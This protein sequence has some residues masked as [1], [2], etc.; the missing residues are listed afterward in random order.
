MHFYF[1][2]FMSIKNFFFNNITFLFYIKLPIELNTY[3]KYLLS[4]KV[5]KNYFNCN[6]SYANRCKT[7]HFLR[8]ENTFSLII[9]GI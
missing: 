8:E 4:Y 2:S 5:P 7:A 9:K 1:I 6:D 3:L